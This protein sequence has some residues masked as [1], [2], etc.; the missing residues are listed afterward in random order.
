MLPIMFII[1]LPSI[2]WW[3]WQHHPH[4]RQHNLCKNESRK[5]KN[6]AFQN[7]AA[8]FAQQVDKKQGIRDCE[9][10]SYHKVPE[11]TNKHWNTQHHGNHSRR[12][13]FGHSKGVITTQVQAPKV[14]EDLNAWYSFLMSRLG[15]QHL[16]LP[17]LQVIL[18]L[19]R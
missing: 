11:P 15:R 19:K 13:H 6:D 12:V 5:T 2:H 9:N 1:I 7:I 17:E 8:D 18:G 3:H 10:N 14:H 16:Y 4:N